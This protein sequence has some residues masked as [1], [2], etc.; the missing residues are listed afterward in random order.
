MFERELI[1][2]E[3][4][5]A[6]GALLAK[7]FVAAHSSPL[8]CFLLV[9]DLGA[10]KT[11][12]VRSFVSA[13]PDGENA[14]IASPSFALCNRYDTK[15]PVLHCDVYRTEGLLAEELEEAFEALLDLDDIDDAEA[16]SKSRA[17]KPCSLV[18]VEWAELLSPDVLPKNRLEVR[19]TGEGESRLV[20]LVPFGEAALSLCKRLFS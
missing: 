19:F 12:F 20:R 15:P 18:I 7:F 17:K 4:T 1:G 11:S 16:F 8:R 3:G 9:G 2:I 10:G 5:E 6:F 13:L 14:D